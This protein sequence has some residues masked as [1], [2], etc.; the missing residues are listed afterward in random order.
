MEKISRQ[1][2]CKGYIPPGIVFV[3]CWQLPI[4]T[5]ILYGFLIKIRYIWSFF[6]LLMLFLNLAILRHRSTFG[7]HHRRCAAW[8]H[9]A[10]K[11]PATRCD[12]MA[13]FPPILRSYLVGNGVG[14]GLYSQSI[15]EKK[16]LSQNIATCLL[17]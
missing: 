6:N 4:F 12:E 8:Q 17:P 15:I 14:R 3:L 11:G 16:T 2:C 5:Y 9:V 7:T 10:Y 1:D 13:H